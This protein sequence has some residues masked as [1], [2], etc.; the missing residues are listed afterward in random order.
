MF[1][2]FAIIGFTIARWL[3]KALK[4]FGLLNL[5]RNVC[6]LNKANIQVWG[7]QEDLDLEDYIRK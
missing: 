3:I 5:K 6:T 2:S 7:P 1:V 4:C